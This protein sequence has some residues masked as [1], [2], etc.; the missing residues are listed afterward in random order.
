MPRKQAKGSTSLQS[1]LTQMALFSANKWPSFRLTKTLVVRTPPG[2]ATEASCE[3]GGLLV[4]TDDPGSLLQQ[5]FRPCVEPQH[6]RSAFE[7]GLRV[8]NV[9]PT[10]VFRVSALKLGIPQLA[11]HSGPASLSRTR[12]A[13]A[14][15]LRTG[16]RA[17]AEGNLGHL[18]GR[19]DLQARKRPRSPGPAVSEQ[20]VFL[21]IEKRATCLPK[22][23]P[24]GSTDFGERLSLLLASLAHLALPASA[25]L[26]SDFEHRVTTLDVGRWQGQGG[27]VV[28][29]KQKVW[30]ARAIEVGQN[31]R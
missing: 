27:A 22:R 31:L 3:P 15:A 4:H 2:R 7:K 20:P 12:C 17:A 26:C 14:A 8:Q 21:S 19:E 6:W 13:S 9:L 1:Q 16:E 25:G 24:F 5:L 10:G 30:P 23:G 28:R 18:C 11:A 29:R